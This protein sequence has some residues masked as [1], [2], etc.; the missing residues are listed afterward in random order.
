MAMSGV[1]REEVED[2]AIGPAKPSLWWRK[3]GQ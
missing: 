2:I 1:G 3:G